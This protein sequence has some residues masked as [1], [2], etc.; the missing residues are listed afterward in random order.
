MG[1]APGPFFVPESP[2]TATSKQNVVNIPVGE[3][4][5]FPPLGLEATNA[6][7]YD[8][9]HRK[10]Y[11]TRA[12]ILPGCSSCA[13]SRL[14]NSLPNTISLPVPLLGG[15]LTK[16]ANGC[17]TAPE[18]PT[19]VQHQNPVLNATLSSLP[20]ANPSPEPSFNGS[21]MGPV[22][23]NRASPAPVVGDQIFAVQWN[24]NGFFHNLPGLEMLVRKLNPTVLALREIHRATPDAMNKTLGNRFRWY[25]KGGT[26]SYRSVALGIATEIPADEIHL[27]S[28]LPVIAVRLSWPFPVSVVSF[29]LPNGKLTNFKMELE[30]IVAAIPE[31]MVLMGDANSHH[32]AWGSSK[33]CSRGSNI[34]NVANKHQLLLLNDGSPTF[35]RGKTVS[36]IDISLISSRHG[37]R[38]FWA[39]DS[40]LHGSDHYPIRLSLT[41]SISPET[42]RRPRW[43]YDE[44]N[45]TNFQEIVDDKLN[46][47]SSS[48][49]A[50]LTSILNSAAT[51]SIP[52]TSPNAGR[53]ALHW[54]SDEAKKAIKMR[55][56]AL[57]ACKRIPDESPK[58][59][60]HKPVSRGP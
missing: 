17:Q 1:S 13:S 2:R 8:I 7:L 22:S 31:P 23:A 43:K 9:L 44:A 30:K 45:W 12:V 19:N 54:W 48:D 35:M 56:K 55:R 51:N 14:A 33:N 60:C 16:S 41:G 26:N 21:L 34:L 36:A 27:D 25:T 18:N 42:S 3:N 52:R 46:E 39:V 15:A 40:D 37:N 50:N 5:F 49:T 58:K 38:F 6:H 11:G 57:R 20:V 24:M 10:R 29:Y 28:E 59:R 53:R 32:H 47:S 4:P